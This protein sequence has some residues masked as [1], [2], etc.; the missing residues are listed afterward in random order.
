MPGSLN[1]RHPDFSALAVRLGRAMGQE[2]PAIAAIRSAEA[3]KSMFNLENDEVGAAMIEL[4]RTD[5]SFS[6]TSAELLEKLKVIDPGFEGR[7]SAKRLAKR[8]NRLWPHLAAAFNGKQDKGHGG[9]NNFYFDRPNGGFGG[10][11]TAF[12]E[13]SHEGKN[14]ESFA[15][16]PLESHQS[17]QDPTFKQTFLP[18]TG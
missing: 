11:E 15:E 8:I 6:G 7:L 5:E 18:T 1:K 9:L 3:D 13:K 2:Q 16:T 10:F 14:V 17:N 4:M 12:S